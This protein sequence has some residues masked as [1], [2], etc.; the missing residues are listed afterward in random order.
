MIFSGLINV[1][2][3]FFEGLLGTLDVSL[4]ISGNAIID[5]LGYGLF[6][7]GRSN[8]SLILKIVGFWLGVKLVKGPVQWLWDRLP[9]T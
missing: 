8:L 2:L 9:L 3:D 1:C 4:D 7:V 6:I 5:V